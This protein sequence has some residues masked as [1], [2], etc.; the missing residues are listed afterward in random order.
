MQY[1]TP[2]LVIVFNRPL[3]TQK[4]FNALKLIRPV[5]LFIAS[6][7]PRENNED[8]T[9]NCEATR[10]VFD[11]IDWECS[12]RKKYNTHNLGCDTSIRAALDWFFGEVEYGIVLEDDCIPNLSFFN[13]CKIVL[14]RHKKDE[15]IA[16]VC[17]S[18]HYDFI[19][20]DKTDYFTSDLM[21]TWGWASWS[22]FVKQIQWDT[23]ISEAEA[24]ELLTVHY[25]NKEF[26]EFYKNIINYFISQPRQTKP[27][28]VEFLVFILKHKLSTIIPSRNMIANKGYAGVHF[29]EKMNNGLFDN[30]TYEYSA[31][32]FLNFLPLNETEK[33]KLMKS[34]MK[35]VNNY[36][37]RDKLYLIKQQIKK[38]L[39][40]NL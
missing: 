5:N 40:I 25:S 22:R 17:G 30:I 1:D 20:S 37:F 39:K 8:D 6:D 15:D 29:N 27:W 33:N 31:K 11:H 4:L 32:T 19:I 24:E 38:I 16:L 36:T 35:K 10:A 9:V 14:E 2:V 28:D 23:I 13:Y 21:Y 26:V 18:N 3:V 12:V 34:F 7:A